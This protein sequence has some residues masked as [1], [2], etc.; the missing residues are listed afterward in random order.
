M[1]CFLAND[2]DAMFGTSLSRSLCLNTKVQEEHLVSPVPLCDCASNVDYV[3]RYS[4]YL[5]QRWMAII[6]S[7]R[8]NHCRLTFGVI[9]PR[10]AFVN[11]DEV[12]RQTLP[13]PGKP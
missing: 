4:T 6:R 5:V 11:S 10:L 7:P 9:R 2:R 8:S 12:A 13:S 1:P 3:D